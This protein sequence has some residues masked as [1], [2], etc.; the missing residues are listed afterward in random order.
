MTNESI[1][2]KVE[3]VNEELNEEFK[4]ESKE[5]SVGSI[6][7]EFVDTYELDGRLAQKLY[8]QQPDTASLSLTSDLSSGASQCPLPHLDSATGLED[9]EYQHLDRYGFIHIQESKESSSTTTLTN[10]M[11]QYERKNE[12]EASRSMKWMNMLNESLER[13]T[14][15]TQ[16]P[17]AHRKFERRLA[18]GVPDSVRSR[19]WPRLASRL[20]VPAYDY[21]SLYLKI[22]G[23][24]RQIDLDIERTLRDHVMFKIRFSQAQVSLFKMLVA[25]SNFDPVVGYCQG[26]STVAA[27]LLLYF[28]EEVTTIE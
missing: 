23:Y 16:W 8:L 13:E 12:K 5:E 21:K 7:S 10:A 19:V 15:V 9:S 17:Q 3:K 26:M 14:D 1:E 28:T 11:L 24:E 22:S 27:F 6:T 4:E 18:K 25:Y 2:I 20:Q